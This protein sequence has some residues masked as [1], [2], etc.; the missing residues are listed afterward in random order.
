M[1][2]EKYGDEDRRVDSHPERG[3]GARFSLDRGLRGRAVT[4]ELVHREFL[5]A[6]LL[7]FVQRI[8]DEAHGEE[9]I[10][11]RLRIRP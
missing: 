5:P 6:L 11:V 4:R 10:E 9:G 7:N 1:I 2:S 3:R 8:I